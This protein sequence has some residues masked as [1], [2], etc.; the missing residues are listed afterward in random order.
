M[1]RVSLPTPHFAPGFEK[2]PGKPCRRH[3]SSGTYL[4]CGSEDAPV[5]VR[6]R[7][8]LKGDFIHRPQFKYEFYLTLYTY[9]PESRP[10]IAV[11]LPPLY[12]PN[13]RYVK[14][15][16]AGPG[17]WRPPLSPLSRSCEKLDSPVLLF[18]S[19]SLTMGYP[20][21]SSR[22][23]LTSRLPVY[24]HWLNVGSW[25]AI[26]FTNPTALFVF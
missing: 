21:L 19:S 11:G 20:R 18:F 3:A 7:A 25:S 13:C 22:F 17:S 26:H 2:V 5:D 6:I 15:S 16:F 9:Y 1:T 24:F 8:V 23:N 14:P 4:T 10:S 12:L